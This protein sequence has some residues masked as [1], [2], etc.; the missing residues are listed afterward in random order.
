MV[1]SASLLPLPSSLELT[2][3]PLPRT[4]LLAAAAMVNFAS[5]FFGVPEYLDEVNIELEIEAPGFNASG[6]PYYACPN[7]DAAQGSLGSAAAAVRPRP[8]RFPTRLL[9]SCRRRSRARDAAASSSSEHDDL[10]KSPDLTDLVSSPAELL[11][12]LLRGDGRPP[13]QVPERQPDAR[14]DGRQRHVAALLI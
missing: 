9:E 3:G 4:L 13:Q 12:A 14:R 5:G 11:Q 2:H 10:L 7:G 8:R 1:K 6:A